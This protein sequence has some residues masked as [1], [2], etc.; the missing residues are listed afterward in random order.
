MV[1]LLRYL[2]K[3]RDLGSR[4][5]VEGFPTLKWFQKGSDKPDNYESGRDLEDLT[6]FVKEKSGRYFI[7]YIYKCNMYV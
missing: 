6:T 4:F 3:H 2:D 5:G 1:C 7:Y